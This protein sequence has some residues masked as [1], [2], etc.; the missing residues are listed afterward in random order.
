MP[1]IKARVDFNHKIREWDGFGVN[2]VETAQTPNYSQYSQDYGGFSTL[3]KEQR[4]EIIN[5]IFGDDGLKPGIIKMFFDP[6]HQTED[7]QNEPGL[8]NICQDNYDHE[9]SSKWTRYFAKEGLK[10][11]GSREEIYK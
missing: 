6:F 10:L 2:Y 8:S 4:Q 1:F 3:S 5:L 7:K 9:T 11:T